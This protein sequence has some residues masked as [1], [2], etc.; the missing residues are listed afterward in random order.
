MKRQP[1]GQRT[2]C[3]TKA[4]DVRGNVVEETY[5]DEKGNPTRSKDGYA[6]ITKVYNS[7]GEVVEQAYFDEKGIAVRK[8]RGPSDASSAT[9]VTP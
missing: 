1:T 3:E 5:F 2:V 9:I 7:R 4:H 8:P 6:K